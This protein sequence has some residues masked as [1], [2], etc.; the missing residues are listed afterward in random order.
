MI[1]H[2]SFYKDGKRMIITPGPTGLF[3]IRVPGLTSSGYP[4]TKSLEL[5]A[6]GL[7]AHSD[8]RDCDPTLTLDDG[9]KVRVYHAGNSHI[10]IV[11]PSLVID[12]FDEK[13]RRKRNK[14]ATDSVKEKLKK[15]NKDR[16]ERVTQP[17]APII[18][19][20]PPVR[21]STNKSVKVSNSPPIRSATSSSD[22]FSQV[23][24]EWFGADDDDPNDG[25]Y[26]NCDSG[27]YP[28]D[29]EYED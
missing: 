9:K 23:L 1:K 20:P 18:P 26:E 5:T 10:P 22:P 3:S 11:Y 14:S 25:L 12:N 6:A 7:V 28:T 27:Y 16:D 15:N 2:I 8:Y 21:T 4:T 19:P 17:M 24:D 13:W 29:D